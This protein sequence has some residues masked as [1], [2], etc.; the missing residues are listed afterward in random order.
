MPELS[1]ACVGAEP[2]RYAAGPSLRLTLRVSEATG[3]RM[4]TV[5]LRC[6]LRIEPQRRTYSGEEAARLADLFGDTSRWADTLKPMQL[7]TVAAMVPAFTGSIEVPLPVPL[8]ADTEVATAKY[9]YGLEDGVIPLLLLFSGTVF[10]Q[11]EPGLQVELVPWHLEA[12]YP[13]PV[14]VWRAVMDEHFPGS[15]WLGVRTET[16]A[17]LRGYRADVGAMNW[18]DTLAR[19]LKAAS[20]AGPPAAPRAVPRADP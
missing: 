4:H 1:F 16:L 12:R 3:V 19:L 18:D 11:G 2:E 7:A 9:F 6:Q 5:A 8:T 15:T 20:S 14:P 17:A 13:L 10:F